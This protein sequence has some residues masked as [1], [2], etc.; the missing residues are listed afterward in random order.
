MF[1]PDPGSEEL[2]SIPDPGSKR[3]PDPGSGSTSKNRIILT[4]N[5]VSKL[6]D[7]IRS[8]PLIADPDLDF[9]PIPDPGVKKAPDP[10]SGPARLH[11]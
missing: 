11:V 7:M 4:Q 9:I 8:G 10:G 2:F 1:I 3:F 6:S 5:I